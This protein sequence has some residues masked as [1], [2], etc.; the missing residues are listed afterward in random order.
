MKT[1]KS[2]AQ[3]IIYLAGP[4]SHP[5][6]VIEQLRFIELTGFAGRLIKKGLIVFSP[7]TMYHPIAI[8]T[9]NLETTFDTWSKI[10][11]HFLCCCTDLFVYALPGYNE[12]KGVNQEMLW[13]KELKLPT[14]L[15]PV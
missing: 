11:Y 2:T 13:A 15:I 7:I 3:R 10:N 9:A 5:N 12:S 1:N 4:Y 14:T 8:A 6:K